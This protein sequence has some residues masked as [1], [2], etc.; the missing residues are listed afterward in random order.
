MDPNSGFSICLPC[1]ISDI[2][3]FVGRVAPYAFGPIRQEVVY[4]ISYEGNI[5]ELADLVKDLEDKRE[6]INNLVEAER[7][8]GKK[9]ESGVQS[10]FEKVNEVIEKANQLREDSHRAEVGCSGWLFPNLISRHR[11]S[12]K[13]TVIAKDVVQVQE[14]GNFERVGYLPPLDE[15]ASSS[16]TKDAE[17]LLETRE[18]FK[19]KIVKALKDPKA[20]NIGVYGLGGVG[21]TTLVK[22]V[23]Q[24][25]KQ[26]K[27]F[28]AVVRADVSKTPDI[29]T[30]QG[31][32]ADL[33]GLRFDEETVAGRAN[34]LRQR[35]RAEKTILVILDDIWTRLD[36][37]KV[38]I[39]SGKDHD[40]CKL[41]MTSRNKEV[42]LEMD[43]LKDFTFRLELLSE[44]ETWRLFQFMA[45]DVVNDHDTNLK[46]VAKQV[47]QKCGGLP[48][49]PVTVARALK[50]RDI[51]SWKD[52]LRKLQSVD[53]DHE[54]VIATTSSDLKL[55][56]D[57]LES[58]ETKQ[59]FLLSATLKGETVEY[60]LKVAMGLGIFKGINTLED[61]RN[62]LHSIIGS[63]KASCLFLEGNTNRRIQM[64]DIVHDVAISIASEDQ[65]VF[66][67]RGDDLEE[68]PTKLDFL[69]S[70]QH[71][72]LYGCHIHELPQRLDCPNIK[73]FCLYSANRSLEIPD[74]IFEGMGSLKVLD[75]TNLHL[76][77]LPTSFR[78]LTDLQT[79]CF[80]HCVLENVDGIGALKNLEIL[81]LSN[82]SIIKLPSE[83]RKL[84]N[85]RLLD[86]SSSRIEVIPPNI[87][88]SLTKLE[89][90][91]LGNTSVKWEGENSAN[92][93]EN[94]SL[95]E[96]GQLP[97]LTALELQ[98][99][100]AWILPRDLK[101]MFEKLKRFKIFIGDAWVW[102]YIGD[103]TLKTLKL[104]LGTDRHLEH[105][106]K[107]LIKAL[108]KKAE[109][110]YLDEVDGIQN[111]L[112][113][114]NLEG[115]PLLK[116]LH[117]QNNA[118]MKHIVDSMER[119]QVKVSFLNL[120]TLVLVNLPNLEE[121][122]H[123][124][125]AVNSFSKL[126]VI[127]VQNC[128]QLKYLLSVLMVKGL[129]QLSEIQVSRCNSME[130]IVLGDGS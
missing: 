37:E 48:L 28:D 123:G 44:A 24:I 112:N 89:E 38:G 35:I 63:L 105:K 43:T 95:S 12:K 17:K 72:I 97:N 119:N 110:L 109:N 56:Y 10:W 2:I 124:T 54:E 86:L 84:T 116:H 115:F 36:L 20:R 55:C 19:E 74:T 68:W 21:K 107:T 126:R 15:A 59:L 76:S 13:A 69:E 66:V 98:I 96:L 78:Y 34:R 53:H 91:Y 83:I 122:C 67:K 102:S 65:H 51:Y 16:G 64:H 87:I 88:S 114:L 108:I 14:K 77:S 1:Q 100:E 60:L 8:S 113:Q 94:A 120:E 80:A 117:I 6:E 41:L 39:P 82:T 25:A 7:R 111:V 130:T 90:L 18:T 71:I 125:L 47:A 104:K 81:S 11:F 45:G 127:K 42:L 73:F 30:I 79:L 129:S 40:G 27:L 106:S 5:K 128:N 23:A 92:Q 103:Q 61:A 33:L 50:G 4:L 93:S 101:V 75:L 46:D 32:I 62:R 22:E 52:A 85:L 58:D 29:R 3:T 31:E 121:I 9:I 70:C 118:N 26:E 49:H 57:R 99:R